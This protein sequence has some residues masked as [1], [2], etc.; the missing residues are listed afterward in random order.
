M[1]KIIMR[2]ACLK[3]TIRMRE[4]KDKKDKKDN[5]NNYGADKIV[6]ARQIPLI[7]L[8]GLTIFPYMVV[9]FDVGR[10][11]SINA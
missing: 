3:G 10:E 5:I 4:K 1:K 7:P 6:E 2:I 9:H 8:R 11:R